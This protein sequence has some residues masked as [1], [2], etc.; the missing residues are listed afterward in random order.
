[1][2]F[3]VRKRGHAGR[4]DLAGPKAAS[5]ANRRRLYGRARGQA[6]LTP[7]NHVVC[8]RSLFQSTSD[9]SRSRLTR[10]DAASRRRGG[11]AQSDVKPGRRPLAATR[12][13]FPVAGMAADVSSPSAAAGFPATGRC[14]NRLVQNP[15]HRGEGP[16]PCLGSCRRRRAGRLPRVS[17]G[18]GSGTLYPT[19]W[20]GRG[21]SGAGPPRAA[22]GTVGLQL[23]RRCSRAALRRRIDS[24]PS[25]RGRALEQVV[26]AERAVIAFRSAGR[27]G[28]GDRITRARRRRD[29][30]ALHWKGACRNSIGNRPAFL[31]FKPSRNCS[32]LASS[33]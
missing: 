31:L 20:L 16:R 14:E 7:A 10:T 3:V 4:G 19:I 22:R 11:L 33:W 30:A 29:A 5:S 23:N 1:M 24:R 12:N 8:C 28:I 18:V 21:G 27:A 32:T 2:S 25:T 26:G 9:R 6:L 15:E 17:G 13:L